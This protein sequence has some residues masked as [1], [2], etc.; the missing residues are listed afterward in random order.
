MPRSEGWILGA[1]LLLGAGVLAFRLGWQDYWWDEHVTL[2][3]TRVSWRELMVDYWDLDTHRPVYYGLQKAWIGIFGEEVAAVRAL[4]AVL[5]LMS[6]PFIWLTAR[7]AAPGSKGRTLAAMAALILVCSPMF[8]YQGRELRMYALM[9]L[10]LSIGLWLMVRLAAAERDPKVALTHPILSWAG[11]AAAM[12]LAFYAHSIALLS[13]VLFGLWVVLATVLRLL[14]PRFL[15]R[16]LPAGLLYGVLILPGLWPF[17]SHTSNTLGTGNFWLP[18]LSLRYVYEQVATA[19]GYPKWTKPLVAILLIWGLWSLRRQPHLALLVVIYVVGL[20]ALILAISVFKPIFMTKVIAWGSIV[21]V[22]PL[23]A[24]LMALR[25]AVVRW[26]AFGALMGAQVVALAGVY[27]SMPERDPFA[28]LAPVFSTF[29]PTRDTLI[30]DNQARMEPPLRWS[31]PQ[32]FE[33]RAYGFS[34]RDWDRNVIDRAFRS[35]FVLRSEAGGI[36][37]GSGRLF[38]VSEPD[39][40]P[41]R[42]PEDDVAAALAIVTAGRTPSESVESP[43]YRVDVYPPQ[44]VP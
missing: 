28:D 31:A 41:A 39:P 24:G 14:P 42:A 23:A 9:N 12:A 16:A 7:H 30:L 4:P 27:P 15:V 5:M 35:E 3:F 38:V 26:A 19:Y 22:I 1:A 17:L 10:G 29:D 21:A 25:P 2:M 34:P 11:L 6:V 13:A 43:R 37:P 36:E 18:E 20:P 40:A 32:L 33:G 44:A 8:V